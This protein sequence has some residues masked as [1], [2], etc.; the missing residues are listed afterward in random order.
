MSL[1][2][3]PLISSPVPLNSHF[4]FLSK[5]ISCLEPDKQTDQIEHATILS[6]NVLAHFIFYCN[7]H[8]NYDKFHQTL[9]PSF[10]RFFPFLSSFI[11][12]YFHFPFPPC[13]VSFC[14]NFL[15]VCF[16]HS[17]LR[18]FCFKC[19]TMSVRPPVI[20]QLWLLAKFR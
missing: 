19:I 17:C 2:N 3:F 7:L 5:F 4:T 14:L 11:Y 16:F 12:S 10:S 13:V 20:Q 1:N 15:T 18:I 8:P 9:L 6:T